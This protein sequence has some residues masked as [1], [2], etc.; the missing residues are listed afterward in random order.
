MQLG[1]VNISR[2]TMWVP[3]SCNQTCK[4]ILYLPGNLCYLLWIQ[5]NQDSLQKLSKIKQN[6]PF[7]TQIMWVPL[8][9]ERVSLPTFLH[10]TKPLFLHDE[11]APLHEVC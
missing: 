8:T 3:H 5:R 7:I 2:S 4:R 10:L 1:V 9:A 6:E 11:A